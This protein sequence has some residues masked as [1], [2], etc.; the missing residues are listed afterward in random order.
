ML[1]RWLGF[2][3]LCNLTHNGCQNRLSMCVHAFVCVSNVSPKDANTMSHLSLT[4]TVVSRKGILIAAQNVCSSVFND[5]TLFMDV[6]REVM[7]VRLTQYE[8]ISRRLQTA[9][10]AW[11]YNLLVLNISLSD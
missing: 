9:C 4:Q 2:N 10:P 8:R 3:Y 5:S 11:I 1:A 6:P 7:D